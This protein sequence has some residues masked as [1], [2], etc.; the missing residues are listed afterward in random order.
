MAQ[1]VVRNDGLGAA[2]VKTDL[3]KGLG[4]TT[5]TPNTGAQPGETLVQHIPASP[6]PWSPQTPNTNN[7][8]KSNAK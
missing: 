5:A 3:N 2:A 4:A 1:E 8:A 7:G 6:A